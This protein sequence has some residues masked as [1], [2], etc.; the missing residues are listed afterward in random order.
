MN[1]HTKPQSIIQDSVPAFTAMPWD[2]YQESIHNNKEN[3]E[4][5]LWFPNE[6][7]KL[8]LRGNTL[9]EAWRKYF[10]LTQSEL[11]EK[12]GM[13]PSTVARLESKN[14]ELPKSNLKE[15]AK[16]LKISVDQLID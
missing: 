15:V 1:A 8:N 11:A 10:K 16:A 4:S 9:V 5:D 13:Q 6:V 3:H 2:Q 12:A 14:A 7:V